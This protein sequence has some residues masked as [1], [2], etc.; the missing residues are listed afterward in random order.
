MAITLNEP[1]V[2]AVKSLLATNLAAAIATINTEG[3][4]S[5]G[6]SIEAPQ[7]LLEYIPELAELVTFP[8]IGIG[9]GNSTFEDDIGSSA[10]GVHE[11]I[12]VVYLQDPDPAAL[13]WRL[14]RYEQA[15]VR[16]VLAGRMLGGPPI[17][18]AGLRRVVPGPMLTDNPDPHA[19]E[20]AWMSY[21]GIV[22][23]AKKDEE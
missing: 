15:I 17:W 12:V 8:T 16:T 5:D 14:R 13:T 19:K 7:Q 18:G 3:A 9:D 2:K 22:I 11:L 6:Y 21:A 20:R 1:V 10:T 4:A 23:W